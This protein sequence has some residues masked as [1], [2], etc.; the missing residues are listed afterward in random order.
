MPIL[1]Q[2]ETGKKRKG[3]YATRRRAGKK[4]EGG[5]AEEQEKHH[6]PES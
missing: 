5:K 2:E 3:K 4:G 6:N 1:K